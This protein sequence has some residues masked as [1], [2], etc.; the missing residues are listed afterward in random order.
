MGD[1]LAAMSAPDPGLQRLLAEA[2]YVRLLARQLIA[3]EA[4]DAEQQAWL[5]AIEHGGE[6]VATPRAWLARIVRNVATSLHRGR[7]AQRRRRQEVQAALT[8]SVP[9]SEEL[10]HQEE[11]RRLLVTAVDR[12]PAPLRAVVLLRYFDGLPPQAIATRLGLPVTTVW[13]QLRR[14]LQLLRERLDADHGG[15]RRAWLAP[16]VPFAW[17]GEPSAA[18]AAATTGG[19][20]VIAGL[21][22]MA[23]TMKTKFA[24]AF[25]LA[26]VCGALVWWPG[27]EVPPGA[28]TVPAP[29]GGQA[30]V[31]MAPLPAANAP[32]P[33]L[34]SGDR[35]AADVV[36][37]AST[38]SL[39]VQVRYAS[40]EAV[41]AGVI[42]IVGRNGAD[43]R[44]DA[45]RHRTDASG[46]ARFAALPPGRIA[47]RCDREIDGLRVDVDAGATTKV[48]YRLPAGV[49]IHG[50][51]V[52]ASGSPV[53]DALVEVAP[54]GA[55]GTMAEELAR[56]ASDGRFDVRT[57]M[58][59]AVVGARARFHA[60]S[61]LRQVLG[62]AVAT[63]PLRLVLGPAAGAVE[64]QVVDEHG[65]LIAG[66]LV[67]VGDGTSTGVRANEAPFPAQ[68]RSD[69]EGRFRALGV[70]AGARRVQ[71][72]AVGFAP[73]SGSVE[74][75][76]FGA[77]PLR[78]EL[79]PG[80]VVHGRVVDAAGQAIAK[81]EV[82]VG[83][84]HDLVHYRGFTAADGGFELVG[85]PIGEVVLMAKH[86]DAGRVEQTVR[87]I[88]GATTECELRLTR[89]LELRGRVVDAQG[90]PVAMAMVLGLAEG[91]GPQWHSEVRTAA[92]GSF[93]LAN[94]PPE[95]S[96]QLQVRAAGF[97]P[98]GR[99]GVG[100]GA[101]LELTLQRAAVAAATVR[102][103]G[104]VL[105]PDGKPV[106][107]V[108]V[109]ANGKAPPS[110][111]RSTSTDASG[112][113]EMGPL[114]A[115]RWSVLVFSQ[116]HPRY[117]GDP[118]EVALD[119]THD[120]GVIRL[121]AGGQATVAVEGDRADAKFY[122]SDR[123][124]QVLHVMTEAAGGALVSPKL[125]PGA[126]RLVVNGK[127]TAAMSIPFAIQAGETT[128]L[129]IKLHPGVSQ[130]FEVF[131][132]A[133]AQRPDFA[134]LDVRR[135]DDVLIGWTVTLS[136]D[137]AGVLELCLPAG[138]YDAVVV[139]AGREL[140][141][142]PFVVAAA[143]TSPVR[144]DLH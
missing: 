124:G 71:A 97:E 75:A 15:D 49:R 41:A 119:S 34:A 96:F 107:G 99:D 83:D 138:A 57:G 122:V 130:R 26:L 5:L 105:G 2:P 72:R 128:P 78:I 36:A 103:R 116:D 100:V 126:Y 28:P 1:V 93:A 21:G 35:E 47:V 139:A 13:N 135:G 48:D 52:D 46:T 144:V 17:R 117:V 70:L 44:V 18:G 141:R 53:A 66:A 43:L 79:R 10:M 7:A 84:W 108:R 142:A 120:F 113:F 76:A 87:T 54:V 134:R 38:G 121:A 123:E 62:S 40:D 68:V 59:A 63:E 94:C 109:M 30:A 60:P 61:A 118:V 39:E 65:A 102:L 91:E 77:V 74:V 8:D 136:P 42:V 31:A 92:D 29:A 133:L 131:A 22:V 110:R 106:G 125:L 101:P 98:F 140:G 89:G 137:R 129:A 45:W 14:A 132:N 19:G 3:D 33:T 95:R 24:A 64:G 4:D 112:R 88:A 73:W 85:L 25:V 111:E 58:E 143:P 9:S 69:A 37:R 127:T 90:A 86:D 67:Q 50:L 27:P 23:M 32:A 51:V 115:G 81:A 12:L 114:P 6:R 82:R 16:L 104:V 20:V 55:L 11:Q 80:G 56:T